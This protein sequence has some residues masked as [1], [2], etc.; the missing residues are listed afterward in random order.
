MS[1][2]GPEDASRPSID[3]LA[4]H[5]ELPKGRLRLVIDTDAANEIDDQFA[6]AHALLSPGRLTIEA[7]TAAP[8]SFA[9]LK[10]DLVRTRDILAEGGP[11]APE[12]AALVARFRGWVE[13]MQAEGVAPEDLAFAGP[14]EGMELSHAEIGRVFSACNVEPAGR[15]HEGAGGWLTGLDA[16]IDSPAARAIIDL[17]RTA[18]ADDPLH[19]ACLGAVTNIAS[20]LMMA[21]DIAETIVVV[22]T[23]GFPTADPTPNR[24]ALNL[25]EDPV[26][27]RFLFDCGVKLVYLPGF[28]IGAQLR[29]SLPEIEA[30]VEPHGAI[31]T[32]LAGLFRNNPLHAQRF[33]RDTAHLTSV[34]W[35]II[36][37]AWLVDPDLVPTV[38]KPAARLGDDLAW[39]PVDGPRHLLR[40]AVGVDRDAIFKDFYDK[41]AAHAG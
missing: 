2:A 19:V 7:V 35:D 37:T 34:I 16:P 13:R 27:S 18:T 31:G 1:R 20:A 21:P 15:I 23:A 36:V 24:W 41:L 40:E 38:L 32:L 14:Q 39:H 17:A 22:W 25:V 30:F 33:V 5:P 6:L 28:F 26:A 4:R 12:D 10:P 29:L 3:N 8:F 9:H 11:H